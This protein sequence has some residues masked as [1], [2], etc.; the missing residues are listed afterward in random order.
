M[1]YYNN[2]AKLNTDFLNSQAGWFNNFTSFMP[3]NISWQMP[4]FFN[5][6]FDLSSINFTKFFSA[7]LWNT[8][9]QQ[10]Y[11]FNFN[12][13]TLFSNYN[14]T[15]PTIGDTFTSSKK[16]STSLQLRLAD[17]AKSYLGKVN[18]DAEGNRLFSGGTKQPWCADFV[19]HV[20][21][22]T[23]GSKLP[24]TFKSFS[25]VSGLRQWG[26]NNGCYSEVPSSGKADF[27]AQN[28]KV[29]DIMIEK[30]GGKSHTGIV[31]KVNSD[32]SFETVEGNC[33]NKVATQHYTAN[34]PTLSGFISLERY[35]A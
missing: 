5:W 28:V 1:T 29:G 20:T 30:D 10:N 12:N 8:S 25:S 4:L 32:G 19:S 3:S 22:E 31:T 33:G 21:K 6:N 11:N 24:S 23:F 34:S 16:G 26:E 18:S 14:F 9:F 27:I 15:T 2:F 13:N 35:T 7:N 17:T